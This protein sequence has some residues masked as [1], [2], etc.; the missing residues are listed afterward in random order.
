[1]VKKKIVEFSH[2]VAVAKHGLS[3][4]KRGP[5]RIYGDVLFYLLNE[6]TDFDKNIHIIEKKWKKN[7]FS[8]KQ[9]THE[10]EP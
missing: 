2:I 3:I 5:N 4:A 10:R 7:R 6:I 1:M 8:C 9:D